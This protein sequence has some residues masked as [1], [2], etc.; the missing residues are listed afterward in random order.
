M[1]VADKKARSSTGAV[2]G[3]PAETK[4]LKSMPWIL[5]AIE[6]EPDTLMKSLQFEASRFKELARQPTFSLLAV[7]RDTKPRHLQELI[8]SVRCQS[9][10]SWQLVLVDDGSRSREHLEIAGTWASQDSRIRLRRLEWPVGPSRSKNL[11]IEESTGDFLILVDGDGVLHP[12]ALGVMARHIND[13]PQVNFVFSN[14][15]EINSHSTSLGNFLLKP[16][17]DLFTLLRISYVSRLFAVERGLLRG[18]ELRCEAFHQAYD[19]IE[20]HDLLIRLASLGPWCLDTRLCSL[21]TAE[22]VQGQ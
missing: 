8:L 6:Q 14:E 18:P 20:E 19:G 17:L 22:P 5:D 21:T 12:M 16:P 13:D 9:Y 15:A 1:V 2:Q 10:E 4:F 3:D 11:A 7:L